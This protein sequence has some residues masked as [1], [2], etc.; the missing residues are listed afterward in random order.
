MEGMT[1][2]LKRRWLFLVGTL[3]AMF[4][5]PLSGAAAAQTAAP[6]KVCVAWQQPKPEETKLTFPGRPEGVNVISPCWF[7]ITDE[8][9]NIGS[10][11]EADKE[12]VKAAKAT[13]MKIWPLVTNGFEAERTTKLLQNPAGRQRAAQELVRLVREYQL[14]GINLDFENIAAADR[15]GLTS[16]VRELS[17]ELHKVSATVSIDVT[18]PSDGLLAE[19]WS[20]C[21]DREALS[22]SVDYVMLMAYDEYSAGSSK[23]GTVASLPWVEQGIQA[24]L[25]EGVPPQKLLLGMP[26]YMRLWSNQDGKV[27]SKTLHMPEAQLLWQQ[28]KASRTWRNDLGQYYFAYTDHGTRYQVWQEDARSLA[29]KSALIGRY[30][31]AGAA[32]WKK[33]VETP[34]VWPVVAA[35]LKPGA[36]DT[37]A[38]PLR[39]I[40]EG[41]YGKPWTLA[42]RENMLQFMSTKKLNTYIY[43]PKD[44]PYHREKWR[45]PYPAAELQ[46]LQELVGFAKKNGVEFVFALSP[47]LDMQFSGAK[48]EQDIQALLRKFDALY[49][50]GVRQFAIFFDDIGNKDGEQQALV[51]NRVN[52]QFVH[53]HADIKPLFTVPTEYFSADMKDDGQLKPYTKAFVDALDKD[54]L[55]LYTGPAVVGEGI[56]K[57]DILEVEQIYG[58]KMAVWWNYPVSD[59]R[60][61]KLAL[62]PITGMEPGVSAHM[63]AFLMNPMEHPELSRIA[64]ATGA[65][66]ALQPAAYDAQKSWKQALR[67]QYGP[68]ASDM[69]VFADHSQRMENDWAHVGRLDAPQFRQHM[70]ALWRALQEKKDGKAEIAVL[71]Q[72]IQSAGKSVKHLQQ[73]LPAA[74]QTEGEP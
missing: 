68:L 69:Q 39:G 55:V 52:R 40:V 10:L 71:R 54:I 12:Y 53:R 29:L 21:Y 74:I 18:V 45:E 70:D 64:L 60:Q 3:T 67:E 22:R 48:G 65:D 27:R 41:F 15:D 49:A 1:L 73:A 31:L 6:E 9:G 51:L 35:A 59:Y 23:A 36:E 58:R 14:D 17:E 19:Y 32:L 7:T 16:F 57:Q 63:A 5:M 24:T 62:G 42:Q 37:A 26:L 43:A 66:Y 8:Q 28:K 46:R 20:R 11:A 30:H 61:A 50:A 33:G 4:L 44:D 25:Q 72:D 38:I 47:G 56:S 13:G 2:I 34:D